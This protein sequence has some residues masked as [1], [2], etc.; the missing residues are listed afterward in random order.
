MSEFQDEY[1]E[2]LEG[3]AS[4]GHP[5]GGGFQA[6]EEA[7]LNDQVTLLDP[8]EPVT[9]H[10]DE[11]VQKA[12]GEMATRR[13]AGVLVVDASGRLVGIFTERDVLTRVVGP[14]RDLGATRL[15]EVMTQDPEALSAQDRIC[16]AINRMNVAGYRTIPLVDDE[17]RPI[18]VVTVNDVMRWLASIFPE[19]LLNLR[20]GDRV[21][22]PQQIDAG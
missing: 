13:R 19:E 22:N 12:V 8:S 11:S 9:L 6:L 17:G 4:A 16:Y 2:T 7:L 20:P 18:G 21:K 3:Q 5:A 10:P 1:S 14:G 15:G